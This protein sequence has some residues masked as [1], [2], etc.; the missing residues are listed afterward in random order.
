MYGF[1]G[2]IHNLRR[3]RV[4]ERTKLYNISTIVM[5]FSLCLAQ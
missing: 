1:P 5:G 2:A 4:R 3:W